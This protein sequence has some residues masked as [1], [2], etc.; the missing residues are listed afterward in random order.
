MIAHSP[1]GE[2]AVLYYDS[3][4]GGRDHNADYLHICDAGRSLAVAVADGDGDHADAAE[5]AQITAQIAAAVAA[6]T[7][8][9]VE[10]LRAAKHYVDDRNHSVVPGREGASS[11]TVVAIN[12]YSGIS[13]AWAGNVPVWGLTPDGQ[14]ETLTV[15]FCHPS[16]TPCSVSSRHQD[17][18]PHFSIVALN[19][20]T[21][22]VVAT[23]GLT[24][25]LT[26]P[27]R[28]DDPT[29]TN[30]HLHAL[31]A[32][33]HDGGYALNQLLLLA[34]SGTDRDNTTIAVIDLL[35]HYREGK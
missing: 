4:A 35:D 11:A 14:V 28:R 7:G 10:A 8:D 25:H 17:A 30:T 5:C 27:D 12:R 23:Q 18:W 13:L 31:A 24:T 19:Q 3:I 32:H 33:Y 16:T 9:P 1:P 26:S 15:P 6:S 20:F 21:R 22:L 2:L 29:A 34:D